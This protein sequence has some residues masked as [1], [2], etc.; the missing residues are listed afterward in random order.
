MRSPN[1]ALSQPLSILG[2]L[3]AIVGA[4]EN[5]LERRKLARQLSEL[6]DHLLRD[7]GV[8]RQDVES[9]LAGSYAY[10][11]SVE[12]ARRAHQARIGRRELAAEQR[13]WAHLAAEVEAY[14]TPVAL[15]AAQRAA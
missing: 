10:D 1:L 2:R 15:K 6:D 14:P 3:A 13:N 5:F 7:I 8:T 11:P 4:V 12:L 9:A